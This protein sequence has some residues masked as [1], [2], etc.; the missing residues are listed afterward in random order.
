M[1]RKV[2]TTALLITGLVSYAQIGGQSVYQ[3][4]NLMSSPRQAA[5]G[6][7]IITLRDYDVNQALFNPASINTEMHNRLSLNYGNYYGEI[8]Y[9]TGSY[10]RTFNSL[11]TFHLGVTYVNYG[12][13]EGRDEFGV[14]T[15]D[16]SGNEVAVSIGYS[17]QIP[18]T[19]LYVGANAKMITSRLESYSSVGGAFDIG[20][21]YAKKDSRTQYAFVMRNAGTQFSTYAGLKEDLPFEL[22]VGISQ[23]LENVPIRWHLNL[24][25]L[26]QWDLSYSNPAR[27]EGNLDGTETQE[28]VSAF[29]NALRH[30]IIGAELF[31]EKSFNIRVGYNFRRGE[32]L[33][34]IDQR[35]FSGLSFGM[36]LR[37]NRIR[38]DYSHSRYTVAANTNLFGLSIQF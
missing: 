21:I 5:L 2:L 17:Y 34:I 10:A 26:Q 22:M 37:M 36:G 11:H 12:D 15:Q 14:P 19:D 7:K 1:I 4:L 16:F 32:E 9:G 27:T 20:I 29:N 3:F 6:G 28:K 24:D 33:K 8:T 30:V 25:N 31:P 13:F 18:E 38:F 35:H 23:R